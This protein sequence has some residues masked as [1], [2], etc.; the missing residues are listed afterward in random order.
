MAT[1]VAFLNRFT[2]AG[3]ADRSAST[4]DNRAQAATKP[5]A[6]PFLLR[7]FP[8]EEIYFVPKR[9]DNSRVVREA[10]PAAA[11]QQIATFSGATVA[12]FLVI[13]LLGLPQFYRTMAGFQVEKLKAEQDKLIQQKTELIVEEASL[14]R[15]ER[16]SELAAAKN[17]VEP[18]PNSVVHLKNLHR[19]PDQ[20]KKTDGPTG[21][22]PAKEIA[23]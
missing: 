14:T 22:V 13:L 7:P 6:Q 1:L 17:L 2:W 9:L 20:A 12:A 11:K 5:A 10:D 23:Q 15:L 18:K 21:V 16:L 19:R 4:V 3:A 8:G